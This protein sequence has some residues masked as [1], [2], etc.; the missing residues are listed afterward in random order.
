VGHHWGVHQQAQDW[1]R[2]PRCAAIQKDASGQSA[3][4]YD[5]ILLHPHLPILF[6]IAPPERSI[7][8]ITQCT[9]H[10]S[11]VSE[12]SSS[13]Q[14]GDTGVKNLGRAKEPYKVKY[15]WNGHLLTNR[16]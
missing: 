13:S 6:H 9:H 1:F 15:I 4:V 11:R 12:S 16:R 5:F 2:H 7:Y 3:D 10:R 14:P 8:Q